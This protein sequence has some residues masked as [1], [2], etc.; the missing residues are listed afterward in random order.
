MQAGLACSLFTLGW[1]VL[2]KTADNRRY[3]KGLDWGGALLS[4]SGVALLTFSLAY[5][6][7]QNESSL[8]S[9]FCS[10]SSSTSKGWGAPHVYGTTI[11]AVTLI[12]LF[13]YY[14]RYR[15]SKGLSVLLSPKIWKKP[16]TKMIP[17]ISMVFFAWYALLRCL[18]VSLMFS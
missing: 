9:R 18:L 17:V 8:T 5:V 1:L 2:P 7:L 10:D 11:A 13:W 4:I 3:T 14:E 16:G 15:E 12:V 6:L